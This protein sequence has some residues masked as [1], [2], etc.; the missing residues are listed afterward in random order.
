MLRGG[1]FKR[2]NPPANHDI[3]M[4]IGVGNGAR[5][6]S[7]AR[8]LA[9]AAGAAETHFRTHKVSEGLTASKEFCVHVKGF[10]RT[11]WTGCR[12]PARP[13]L[14][15]LNLALTPFVQGPWHVQHAIP[16]VRERYTYFGPTLASAGLWS[17]RKSNAVRRARRPRVSVEP[18]PSGSRLRAGG[19]SQGPRPLVR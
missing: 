18:R 9:A 19:E 8:T 3:L 11:A 17:L 14:R 4:G 6:T 7:R 1:G 10:T 12:P 13:S 16:I 2:V 5:P 15:H